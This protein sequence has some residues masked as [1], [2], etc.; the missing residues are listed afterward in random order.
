MS[1]SRSLLGLLLALALAILPASPALAYGSGAN[2]QIGLAGTGV[3]PS[4]GQGFGFWGWCALGGGVTSGNT[5]DCQFSQYVHAGSGGG[6]TCEISLDINSWSISPTHT[7]LMSGT[8]SANPNSVTQPCLS[9]FP[10]SASFTNLDP[11]IP[12]VPGHYNLGGLGPGLV[13]EFQTQ[14]TQVP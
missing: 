5:G 12:A 2:W 11:G 14:V 9:F 8:A 6:F 13:G 1:R 3:L 7:F 10:G 4:T